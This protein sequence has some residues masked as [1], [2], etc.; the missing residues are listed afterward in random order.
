VAASRQH[1]A[2]V[3]VTLIP[4]TEYRRERW[5][6]GLGWTREV[7]RWPIDS[8]PWDWRISIA[9]VDKGGPFSSFPGV[10]RELVLLSGEGMR[11]NFEDGEV[12]ELHPPHDRHRFAGERA[13][14]AELV[15][16]PTQDFNLMWRRGRVDA[17]VLHR[18]LVGS[19]LF[20][21]EP[22]VR[23]VAY[24]LSGRAMVKDQLLPMVLEQGDTALLAPQP[25]DHQ[26]LIIEGGGELLLVRIAPLPP[27]PAG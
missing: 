11:L 21:A 16:G 19:M 27:A 15:A 22:G 5:K 14:E 3:N 18:P 6:N 4:A 7:L 8:D 23:W 20:F 10:D 26:R 2:G 24:L 9:E 12:V 25:G 13:L 17:S 1:N